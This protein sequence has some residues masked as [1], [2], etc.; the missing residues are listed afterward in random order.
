[1][2]FLSRQIDVTFRLS[3]APAGSSGVPNVFVESG[4]NTVTLSGL[5]VIA[6]IV[7]AGGGTM[8]TLDMAV[9]GMTL[10]IMN[11]LSTLGQEVNFIPNNEVLVAAGDDSGAAKSTVF[12]GNITGQLGGS[13]I[14]FSDP[15]NVAFRVHAAGLG[16]FA[17]LSS[18][19]QSFSG[20]TDVASILSGLATQMDCKFLNN[21]VTSKLNGQYLYGPPRAQ[22]LKV[23]RAALPRIEWNSG[24]GGVL[25]I[26][27]AT[28]SRSQTTIPVI[29]PQSGMEGYPSYTANGLELTTLFNPSISFGA[30]VQ[31]KSSLPAA[32]Q[33]VKV[34]GLDHDLHAQIPGGR[35][36]S[37][38]RGYNPTKPP[39]TVLPP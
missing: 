24:E 15:A 31:V 13:F 17:V 34:M 14:D 9:Y 1:M 36:H 19:P 39:G 32:N 21:G 35:W 22:A 27:P 6:K 38:I 2:S 37:T 10:S 29:S 23:V 7:N 11:R 26:W 8:P 12:V 30:L 5:R 20:S 33:V 28:G 4:T 3:D 18:K 25:A 16:V